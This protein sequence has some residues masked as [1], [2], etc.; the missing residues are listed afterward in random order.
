MYLGVETL[1]NLFLKQNSWSSVVLL[2]IPA[3]VKLCYSA[4]LKGQLPQ[5]EEGD[6]FMAGRFRVAENVLPE[7]HS[8]IYY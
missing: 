8:F 6:L 3:Y 4:Y 2:N 7:S 1:G 5:L